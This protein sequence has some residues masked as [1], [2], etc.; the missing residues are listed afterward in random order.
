MSKQ[1]SP[2]RFFRHV[3]NC[4]LKQYFDKRKLLSEVDLEKLPETKIESLYDGWLNLPEDIRH[5]VEQDFQQIDEM[6]TEAGSKAIMDEANWHGENLAE[7][8]AKLKGFLER[9]FWT[10]LERPQYWDVAI[11][12]NH[13]DSIPTPYWRKRKNVPSKD[14]SIIPQRIKTFENTL[15]NYF[16]TTQGR[17]KNCKVEHYKR[18]DLDYFFAYPEDYA[19]ANIEWEGKEFKRRAYRP[20]FE[21]IFVYSQSNCT[22]DIFVP[23][24]RKILPDLQEIFSTTILQEVLVPDEKDER[25]YDLSRLRDRYFQF[26]YDP[27]SGIINVA[28]RKIRLKIHNQNAKITLE[29]DPTHRNEA[30]YD[31]LDQTCKSIQQ[32][33]IAITQVSIKATFSQNPSSRRK[34]TCSFDITWP[35]SCSLKYDE[36]SLIIR[37]ML[38]DSNIEPK[39]PKTADELV[40]C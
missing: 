37:K 30:I 29:A 15:G 18:N 36:R 4:L 22:L 28:V 17:G 12:F 14:V 19:Q 5:E 39:L 10:F 1:Y 24:D 35:N 27:A 21:I 7:Q 34:S 25:V 26:L 16:Y 13:A 6:A 38:S 3:P 32:N 40:A 20:A 31:L 33:Q 2:K 9:A 23:G 8:F 11:A